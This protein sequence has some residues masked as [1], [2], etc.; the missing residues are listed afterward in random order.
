MFEFPFFCLNFFPK[1]SQFLGCILYTGVHY[2][3]YMVNTAL[4]QG[5]PINDDDDKKALS[6]MRQGSALAVSLATF[7]NALGLQ[8]NLTFCEKNLW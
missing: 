3:M 6:L 4:V 7:V 5:V 1:C 2:V 8:G